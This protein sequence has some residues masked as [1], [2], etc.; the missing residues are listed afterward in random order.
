[1]EERGGPCDGDLCF[2]S[3]SLE[4]ENKSIFTF[5]TPR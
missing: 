5:S 2:G 4:G 1:M 3:V